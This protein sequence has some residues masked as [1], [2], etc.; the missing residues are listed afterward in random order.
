MLPY[1]LSKSILDAFVNIEE[2]IQ[3][4][5]ITEHMRGNA[6]I[7]AVLEKAN[8]KDSTGQIASPRA[9]VVYGAMENIF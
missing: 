8:E 9:G 4:G 3:V 2:N 6:Q 7:A 5:N 1:T